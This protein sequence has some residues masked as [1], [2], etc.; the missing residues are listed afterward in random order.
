MDSLPVHQQIAELD[1]QADAL[2][3]ALARRR[4]R[5]EAAAAVSRRLMG[6]WLKTHA[7]FA[8]ARKPA[9]KAQHKRRCI[10]IERQ[11][12]PARAE[13][14]AAYHAWA[15]TCAAYNRLCDRLGE[16][17]MTPGTPRHM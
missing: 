10:A 16:L 11:L 15:A 3:P 14:G 13:E 1:L 6:R 8:R 5:Y 12:S 17:E 7:C 4:G 2:L 9:T